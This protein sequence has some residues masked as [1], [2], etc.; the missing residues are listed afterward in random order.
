MIR[1]LL[2]RQM[3]NHM[4]QDKLCLQFEVPRVCARDVETRIRTDNYRKR[5]MR[6]M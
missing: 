1:L 5:S 2:L 6:D 3:T 4:A